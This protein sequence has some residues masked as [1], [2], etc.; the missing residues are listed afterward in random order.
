MKTQ[1]SK[2]KSPIFNQDVLLHV[3]PIPS[4]GSDRPHPHRS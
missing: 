3:F 4:G 1:T 2:T